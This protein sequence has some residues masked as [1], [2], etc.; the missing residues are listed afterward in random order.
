MS[1][2]PY[3]PPFVDREKELQALKELAE[4]GTPIPIYVY[5]PEGCGKTR[6]LREFTRKFRGVAIYVN[7]LE[8]EDLAKA[9]TMTPWT[10]EL[11]ESLQA[12]A[13]ILGTPLGSHLANQIAHLTTAIAARIKLHD[14][15]LVIVVDDPF[16][17]IGIQHADWYMKWLQELIPRIVEQHK[18]S[19]IL[20]VTTTSEGE[21][22]DIVSKHTYTHP[23]LVWNLPYQAHQKLIEH[24][25]PPPNIDTHSLWRLTGGNPRLLI[26]IA[27]TYNWNT[28]QW[29]NHLQKRLKRVLHK[30]KQHGLTSQL[31][32]A[33]EDPD[34]LE[35][36]Q[37]LYHILLKENLVIYK[38]MPTL[39]QEEV[40]SD[41]ELGIGENYAWQTPAYKTA[42][43]TLIA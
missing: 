2:S 33:I 18:P 23:R 43:E 3:E 6:L 12:L 21:T 42:L 34:T 20:V 14:K 16:K 38:D 41:P 31:K 32:Q 26:D 4:R 1:Y 7:A 8:R 28:R 40:K 27:Y 24:L 13:T 17:A 29:L 5:G 10:R 39:T 22:L 37:Q 25:N 36:N 19:S 15:P 35:E 9:V 30:I 11:A